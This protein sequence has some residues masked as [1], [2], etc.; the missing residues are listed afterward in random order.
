[1]DETAVYCFVVLENGQLCEIKLPIFTKTLPTSQIWWIIW[2]QLWGK[3]HPF[4]P[5]PQCNSECFMC[6]LFYCC[7]S[8]HIYTKF[9]STV[10]TLLLDLDLGSGFTP[11]V[12]S[13][14]FEQQKTKY[15]SR[16]VVKKL[17]GREMCPKVVRF[18]W[19]QKKLV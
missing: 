11:F 18:M 6:W 8:S 13:N 3:N 10:W 16:A 7:C 15:M 1:M 14:P 17:L 9:V 19:S 5:K 4:W 12:T 2:Y